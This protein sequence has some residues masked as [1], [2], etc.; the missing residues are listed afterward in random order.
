MIPTIVPA[1]AAILALLY[2]YLSTRVIRLRTALRVAIGHGG[3]SILERT[4]RVHGNFAEY[5]PFTLLLLM[6]VEMQDRPHWL[7]HALCLALLAAR[8]L[9]AY[10]VSQ[11]REDV[12][13][14]IIGAAVTF[15]VIGIAAVALLVHGF[16]RIAA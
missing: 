8:L 3:H 15:G 12:R 16:I 1:Y 10:G 7:V 6:F 4:Q 11:E 5:V 9:H 14:R 2:I 13:I